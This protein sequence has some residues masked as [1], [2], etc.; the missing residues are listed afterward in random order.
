MQ[1]T[2]AG[3]S[4]QSSHT[5]LRGVVL[6]IGVLL[7]V[8]L[9]LADKTNLNTRSGAGISSAASAENALEG[10]NELPPLAPD[11]QLDS[12]ISALGN[13]APEAKNTLLDSIITGLAARGRYD[14]A[15]LYANQRAANDPSPAQQ[16]RAGI[17]FQR[18]SKLSHISEDSALFSRYSQNAIRLLES[19]LQDEPGQTEGLYHLGLALVESRR[20][21]NSMQGIQTLRKVL[22]IDPNH[23]EATFSL[24][25]FSLQTGQFDKAEARFRKALELNP[26]FTEAQFQL[27]YALAEQGKKADARPLLEQ[28]IRTGKSPELKQSARNL[29]NTL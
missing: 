21:E 26:D 19:A 11:E 9:M 13:A 12:W 16:V 4:P 25:M 29:L 5:L 1:S 8:L 3:S 7:F 22:E 24:G 20:P 28:V 18:A 6:G 14:H 2:G 15:A 17:L 10:A 23:L 27:A